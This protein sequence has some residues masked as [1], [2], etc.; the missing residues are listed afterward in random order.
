MLTTVE[1]VFKN[2][3]IEL[4]EMPA[5]IR[6]ARVIVTFLTERTEDEPGA[7]QASTPEARVRAFRSFVASL[8]EA[9]AVPLD[10]L[11]PDRLSCALDS[12]P[13]AG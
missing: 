5:K 11:D 9:P 8:P 3:H 4:R 2:G 12:R 6:E 1:G 10:A 7:S 13:A